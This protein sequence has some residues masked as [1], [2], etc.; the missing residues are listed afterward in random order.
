M[1]QFIQM[2]NFK[3]SEIWTIEKPIS[4]IIKRKIE[5]KGTPLKDWDINI[6]RGILTGYNKAFIIPTEIRRQILTNCQTQSEAKY[7]AEIIRPILRGRDIKK[8]GYV[9]SNLWIISTFPAR[10]YDINKFPALRDYLLSHGIERL[11]QTGETHIINGEKI[12]SRKKTRNKWYETQDQINYWEDFLKPKI[13]YPNMT[14]FLPFYYDEKGFYQNDKSFM[15]TGE[16]IAYLTAFFNSSLF[17]FCFLNNFPEL[18]GGTRE[19]RKVFFEKIPVLK[20][21]AETNQE[22][23][24]VVKDIQQEYTKEKAIRID[25]MIFD[26]YDLNEE[27]RKI[28]GFIDIN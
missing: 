18:L 15:I 9:W 23:I 12:K 8:Y 14:K 13:M 7:T 11:E 19:V 16:S 17:K 21:S 6:N 26:L 27:E 28:I 10:H 1:K 3:K 5:A 22:F 4:E 24:K 2:C 20:V 25:K